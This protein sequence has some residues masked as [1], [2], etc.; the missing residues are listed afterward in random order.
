MIISESK[1]LFEKAQHFIPGGVNSPRSCISLAVG[2]IHYFIKKLME[3]LSSI[4][5]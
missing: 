4:E 2:G 5:D 3:H 1:R